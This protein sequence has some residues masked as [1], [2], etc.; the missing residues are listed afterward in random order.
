[1]KPFQ[2]ECKFKQNGKNKRPYTSFTYMHQT[3]GQQIKKKTTTCVQYIHKYIHTCKIKK[4]AYRQM[5]RHNMDLF[6]LLGGLTDRQ[7][8]IGTI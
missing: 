5:P 6:H 3:V 4:K 2:I 1:M 8:D 7:A